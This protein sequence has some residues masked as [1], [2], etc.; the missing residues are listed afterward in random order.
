MSVD[1]GD[2]V[3]V[4]KNILR[5]SSHHAT[6]LLAAIFGCD[7]NKALHTFDDKASAFEVNRQP[8][9][10]CRQGSGLVVVKEE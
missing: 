6:R 8:R 5:F 4:Y 10:T 2:L 9:L 7:R 3:F 1:D